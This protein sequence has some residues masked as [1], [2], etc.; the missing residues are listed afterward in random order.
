MNYNAFTFFLASSFF[1]GVS[2]TTSVFYFLLDT[3]NNIIINRKNLN[4]ICHENNIT[5]I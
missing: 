3:E 1:I 4:Y 5:I 2:F